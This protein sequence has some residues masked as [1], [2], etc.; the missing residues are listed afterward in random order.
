M[1]ELVGEYEESA[2]KAKSVN[3][4][5]LESAHKA[6]MHDVKSKEV[7]LVGGNDIYTSKVSPAFPRDDRSSCKQ[8]HVGSL[9]KGR[10]SRTSGR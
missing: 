2:K 9:G 8:R 3:K 7:P 4:G 10:S 1:D 6:I 5:D